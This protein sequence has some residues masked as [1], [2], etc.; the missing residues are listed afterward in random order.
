MWHG[1]H[2]V[3]Q[4]PYEGGV[5]RFSILIPSTFPDGECPVRC[6]DRS[7]HCHPNCRLLLASSAHLVGLPSSDRPRDRRTGYQTVF[8]RVEVSAIVNQVR[9]DQCMACLDVMGIICGKFCGTSGASSRRSKARMRR[10]Q[11]QHI[12]NDHLSPLTDERLPC[13]SDTN[14]I[15]EPSC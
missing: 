5:F 7:R 10:I 14:K 2:F 9:D 15:R 3:S 11:T 12:C 1:I 4:G 8:S 13:I 6:P